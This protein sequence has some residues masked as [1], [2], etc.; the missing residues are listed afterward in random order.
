MF[1][2]VQ[3]WKE[4]WLVRVRAIC[5]NLNQS[6]LNSVVSLSLWELMNT[7]WLHHTVSSFCFMLTRIKLK[8]NSVVRSICCVFFL[9]DNA[10][11]KLS[12]CKRDLTRLPTHWSYCLSLSLTYHFSSFVNTVCNSVYWY[13]PGVCKIFEEFLK[14]QNPNIPSITY[15]ISQLFDFI[16]QLADLSCLV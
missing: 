11:Q 1:A 4:S 13:F 2:S 7:V 14:R 5:H 10:F 12:W 3:L 8:G 15:D 9:F 6:W 16:D